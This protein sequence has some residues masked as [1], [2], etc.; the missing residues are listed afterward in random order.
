MLRSSII[1]KEFINYRKVTDR[2][3]RTNFSGKVRSKGLGYIPIV[4][5][6]VDHDLSLALSTKD[7]QYSRSI[8]YGF[9]LTLHMDLTVA[10]LIKEIKIEFLKKD[11]EQLANGL[12]L[13]LEDG[14]IL[15]KSQILGDLYKES[16][17]QDDKIL[18]VLAT[19]ETSV[20]AYI[21]SIL[22]YLTKNVI[23]YF[24]Q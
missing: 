9:E 5:D 20:F 24:K 22:K 23:S 17:N 4:V 15:E 19:K 21:L 13:G 2:N 3:R 6:S 11:Q 10:D 18:Y 1:G 8:R 16:R 12:V 14:T 7:T